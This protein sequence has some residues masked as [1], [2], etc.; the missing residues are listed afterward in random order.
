MSS[1]DI[2]IR[3]MSGRFP[4]S[5]NEKEFAKNLYDGV[6]MITRNEDRRAHGNN[7]I[8]FVLIVSLNIVRALLLG[9]VFG[10]FLCWA[11]L[12]DFS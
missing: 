7:I 6:Y 8:N 3:G 10:R 2:V 5:D 1:N 9:V 11:C 12:G 4:I